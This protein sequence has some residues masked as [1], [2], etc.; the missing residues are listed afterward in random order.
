MP[1][2][3]ALAEARKYATLNARVETLENEPLFANA[4]Q[5]QR[6]VISLAAVWEWP[7]SGRQRGR[8]HIFRRDD[9]PLLVAGL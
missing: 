3:M 4:F 7:A 2:G 6:C 8:V 1:P 5:A 9:K